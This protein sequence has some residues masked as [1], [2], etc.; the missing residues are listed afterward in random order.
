MNGPVPP[1][2]S[3]CSNEPTTG[4]SGTSAGGI[5]VTVAP[6]GYSMPVSGTQQFT[7]TVLGTSNT[8]VNWSVDGVAGGNSTVGTISSS[9]LYTAP[10][11]NGEHQITATSQANAAAEGTV[12]VQ[13]GTGTAGS[14]GSTAQ[15]TVTPNEAT[16]VPGG[17]QQ[18]TATVTGYTGTPTIVWSVNGVV[19]G[20]STVGTI[21]SSGLF[22]A[23]NVT[24]GANVAAVISGTSIGGG[25]SVIVGSPGEETGSGANPRP[26]DTL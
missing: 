13:V 6:S 9:G 5:T 14:T 16:V 18:F 7:A 8:A 4:G 10:A 25:A 17:T 12:F 20:N 1:M 15:L 21:S 24:G 3:R 19:G 22:T 26:E 11:T 2:S 23:P